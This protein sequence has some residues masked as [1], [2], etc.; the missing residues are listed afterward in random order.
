MGEQA[1]GRVAMAIQDAHDEVF[2][3]PRAG[4]GLLHAASARA[5]L[6]EITRRQPSGGG[7]TV[8]AGATVVRHSPAEDGWVGVE[9]ERGP[10]V[11]GVAYH[12][13]CARLHADGGLEVI[14]LAARDF[15]ARVAAAGATWTPGWPPP[16]FLWGWARDLE[17][18]VRWGADAALTE[19]AWR[20]LVDDDGA[21][22]IV[23]AIS[24]EALHRLGHRK[25]RPDIQAAKRLAHQR[26]MTGGAGI[27]HP[28][29]PEG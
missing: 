20:S 7:Y 22:A 18:R 17:D 16:R 3:A 27:V 21:R 4:H 25:A 13:W 15:P 23:W 12:A 2:G 6:H 29:A 9:G 5:V 10:G 8:A 11:D 24:Q 14:D 26:A 1:R 19:A 28:P